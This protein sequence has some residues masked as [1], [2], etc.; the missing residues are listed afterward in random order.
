MEEDLK[1]CGDNREMS[2]ICKSSSSSTDRVVLQLQC[3]MLNN[4]KPEYHSDSSSDKDVAPNRIEIAAREQILQNL[5]SQITANHH[6]DK[7]NKLCFGSNLELRK[8]VSSS[9][10]ESSCE[11][12]L[13]PP[14]ASCCSAEPNL[15]Y[16]PQTPSTPCQ[17]LFRTEGTNIWPVSNPATALP[18]LCCDR[19]VDCQTALPDFF[20]PQPP[21][22]QTNNRLTPRNSLTCFLTTSTPASQSRLRVPTSTRGLIDANHSSCLL[23]PIADENNSMSPI[24][25]STQKMSKA[26]QVSCVSYVLHSLFPK[27][28]CIMLCLNRYKCQ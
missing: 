1:S 27:H 22:G 13:S 19:S 16:F 14:K 25:R 2:R 18:S 28:M 4:S 7:P 23:T 20:S 9:S 15:P 5:A 12:G 21:L 11:S 17:S 10:S 6:E 26:M 8:R 24:T 3:S